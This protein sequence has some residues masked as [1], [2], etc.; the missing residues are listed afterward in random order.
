MNVYAKSPV[1]AVERPNRSSL[2]TD[3]DS[4]LVDAAVDLP[5]VPALV[6][7]DIL[8][9]PQKEPAPPDCASV[10]PPPPAFAAPY[11]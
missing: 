5:P 3:A 8:L 1:S 6:L 2:L 11:P 10:V 7:T 4:A 9:L